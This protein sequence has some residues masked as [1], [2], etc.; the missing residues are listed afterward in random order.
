MIVVAVV[1]KLGVGHLF[2]SPVRAEVGDCV[3]VTGSDNN[4]DVE[5]KGCDDKDASYK[6]VKVVDNAFDI[7]ACTVRRGRARAGVGRGQVRPLPE[8]PQEVGPTGARGGAGRA[9][10]EL[11]R[12]ES[13]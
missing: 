8:P 4:P 12:D 6:V 1:V 10:R 9:R 2:N 13:H 7:N 5:T 11:P 3:K